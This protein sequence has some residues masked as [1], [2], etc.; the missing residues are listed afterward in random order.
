MRK[1]HIHYDYNKNFLYS[2]LNSHFYNKIDKNVNKNPYYYSRFNSVIKR[3]LKNYF[4][5]HKFKKNFNYTK[6]SNN[7]KNFNQNKLN[8]KLNKYIKF[9]HKKFNFLTNK[10]F[11][12]LKNN[13]HVKE[14][15][16]IDYNNKIQ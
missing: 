10:I 5:K 15:T 8:F 2:Y 16:K 7:F 1:F 14:N 12:K 3:F 6:N 13:H 4:L 9:L 11:F